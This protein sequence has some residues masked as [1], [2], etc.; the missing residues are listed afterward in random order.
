VIR[1]PALLLVETLAVCGPNRQALDL[2]TAI[3]DSLLEYAECPTRE[4]KS[5]RDVADLLVEYDDAHGDCRSKL[6]AVRCVLRSGA[7]L[8]P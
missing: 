1:I 8:K 4:V 3:P 6:E 5:Q 2:S 7:E